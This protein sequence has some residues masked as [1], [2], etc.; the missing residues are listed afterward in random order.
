[1]LQRLLSLVVKEFLAIWQDTKS[2][3]MLFVPP[4]LQ[5][6][7]FSWAATLDVTNVTV[8][9]LNLDYG[10]GG[11]ELT[12]RFSGSPIFKNIRF[13]STVNE[14]V[15]EID[16]QKSMMA[17]YIDEDFSRNLA[18]GHS[19][20]VQVLLDGRKSNTAQ[21]V[22]GY[23]S[24][25]LETFTDEI[26][27]FYARPLLASTLIARNWFNPNLVYTWFTVTGLIVLLTTLIVISITS[28]SVARERELGTF[29]Q[30]LVSPLTPLDILLGKSIP[31]AVIGMIE[32]TAIF[33][34]A[35]F[36]YGIPFTGS[37]ILFYISMFVFIWSI[38]GVG[39]FISSLCRTQQQAI[40]GVFVFMSPAVILSGYATPIDNM[41]PWLQHVTL[42]NPLRYFMYIVRG[43]IL[44]D[45]PV[46]EVIHSLYPMAL[47]AIFTLSAAVILFR[48]RTG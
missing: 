48:K 10:K 36:I 12:Q 11:Y 5:L 7:I 15:E 24:E 46:S 16:N 27:T 28:L 9:V 4:L 19:A 3:I 17:I 38:V 29:E 40:L 33:L 34:A 26:N 30:L 39:L 21:I 42:I 23:S 44:K 32:G 6:L 35:L 8:S 22:Q 41:P 47:I 31:A 25:I 14:I 45:L 1:M 13:L 43:V 20:H 2:R 37:I 18:Y